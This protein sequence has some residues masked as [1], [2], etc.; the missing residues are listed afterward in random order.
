MPT[1]SKFTR[2]VFLTLAEISDESN[3]AQMRADFKDDGS[4]E[5][6]VRLAALDG[7]ITKMLEKPV[8]DML[9]AMDAAGIEAK[10]AAH[11]IAIMGYKTQQ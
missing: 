1:V 8:L 4:F 10:K 6:E 5:S 9:S 11:A 3:A 2:E 7:I